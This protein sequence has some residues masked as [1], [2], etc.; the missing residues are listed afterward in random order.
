MI[1]FLRSFWPW[2]YLCLFHLHHHR[3]P[4][5]GSPP[6]ANPVNGEANAEDSGAL[7]A[8][9]IIVDIS[10]SPELIVISADDEED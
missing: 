10:N 7:D 5:L 8:V 3:E 2:R 4:P 9:H 6:H 1:L